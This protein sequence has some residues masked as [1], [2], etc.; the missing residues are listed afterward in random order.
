[1]RRHEESEPL[2]QGALNSF[3]K[4]LASERDIA[5][6]SRMS[7]ALASTLTWDNGRSVVRRWD[8]L[9]SL[10]CHAGNELDHLR[11]TMQGT[12]KRKE[13]PS[14]DF[15]VRWG[16]RVHWSRE[17]YNR[18]IAAYRTVRL[19]EVAGLPP[20][21]S[22]R[23]D[24]F[25]SVGITSGVL[26]LAAEELA[27]LIP[28]LAVRLVLRLCAS[29]T[30]D[31]LR[32]VITRTSVATLTGESATSLARICMDAIGYAQPRLFVPDEPRAGISPIER[33][34]VA[35]EVLSRLVQ[36]LDPEMVGVTLDIA[37]EC[38][39]T[40]RIMQHHWLAG[41]A[42]N[43]LQRSW[44]AL[45]RR[46]RRRR[47]FD[48][49]AS[50]IVGMDGY[51]AGSG[52]QDPTFL[53]EDTDLPP[54]VSSDSE[55]QYREVID[56]LLRGL[57]SNSGQARGLATLRLLRLSE[58]ELLTDHDSQA[59]AA[60]LWGD[61]DPILTNPSGPHTPLDW[62]FMLLPELTHGQAE[63]SF[64]RKWLT[65]EPN[66]QEK[67]EDLSSDV[68]GQLGHAFSGLRSRGRTLALTS[69]DCGQIAAHI[70]RFVATFTSG[71]L[72]I[73][74]SV[75][76]AMRCMSESSLEI[77][78]PPDIAMQLYEDARVLIAT[79]RGQP[80]DPFGSFADLGYDAN[81]S[82]GYALVPGL[83]KASPSKSDDL[84]MLLSAGL[85]SG[86]D[87]RVSNAMSALHSWVS[88]P[89]EFELP[90][91]PDG[92][93]REVGVIISSRRRVGLVDALSF[94]EWVFDDG[95]QE[96]RDA[97][98]TLIVHG[99]SALAEEMQYDRHQADFDVPTIRLFCVRLAGSM[100]K[101]GFEGHP[102]IQNW[103]EIGKEDPFPEVRSAVATSEELCT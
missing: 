34:R 103:M 59:F 10:R 40:P 63:S 94:A 31:T 70:E 53:I 101:H 20:V 49:L 2:V 55:D 28:E 3:R 83:V 62:A 88:A 65:E 81:L 13:A 95:Q 92:L 90:P 66:D 23:G 74:S 73:N 61:S 98:A 64:R 52:F 27:S 5:S 45:S 4:D 21:T 54:R 36:R 97:I 75:R 93:V 69:E 58:S 29:D 67:Y 100:A 96:H 38:H 80:N 6:A 11:L 37:I 82:V 51:E 79:E 12:E 18:L 39:R 78:V 16:T 9:A 85:A 30:N 41:P 89:E 46:H 56:L 48:L 77:S 91:P 87:L 47:V 22:P 72:R 1:M 71:A 7:W 14:F 35:I 44:T 24:R 42:G 17:Q 33:M 76:E 86:D 32:R 25:G 50:P 15:G 99:L 8:E 43:L 84:A 102:A 60:I 19:P 57:R 26:T 68:I